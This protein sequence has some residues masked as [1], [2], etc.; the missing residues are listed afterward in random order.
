MTVF[1]EASSGLSDF[2]TSS[3]S[4]ATSAAITRWCATRSE[5]AAN[6]HSVSRDR[7]SCSVSLPKAPRLC[8]S[9]PLPL[10]AALS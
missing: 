8:P 4:H 10:P 9:R 2:F 5:G 3:E 7:R 6:R 1:A